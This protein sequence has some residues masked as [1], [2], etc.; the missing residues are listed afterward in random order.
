[1]LLNYALIGLSLT[2]VGVAGL[3]FLYLFY[4]GRVDEQ[5]KRHIHDLEIQCKR[6]AARLSEAED[7]I[8]EQDEVLAKFVE[9]TDDEV[10]A[11]I[12]EER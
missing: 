8:A 12:I 3:Q 11:D 1:M 9:T 2:L 6:L 10:W 7:H 4:L 5:R